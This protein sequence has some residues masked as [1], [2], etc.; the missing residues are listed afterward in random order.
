M[1]LQKLWKS[2]LG[3]DE[4]FD[5]VLRDIWLKLECDHESVTKCTFDRCVVIRPDTQ[6]H[7]FSDSGMKANGS[8]IY[9]ATNKKVDLKM[10][11]VRVTPI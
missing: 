3:W 7:T 9:T 2:K 4:D 10:A 8:V 5:E 6:I 1:L 11:K